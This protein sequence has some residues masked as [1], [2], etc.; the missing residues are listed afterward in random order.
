[1]CKYNVFYS[2]ADKNPRILLEGRGSHVLKPQLL[3]LNHFKAVII[4]RFHYITRNWRSLFSQVSTK[5]FLEVTLGASGS[6]FL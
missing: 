2:V 3:L 5:C 4:K 1:V 6:L